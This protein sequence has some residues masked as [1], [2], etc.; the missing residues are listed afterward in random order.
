MRNKNFIISRKTII[1]DRLK[2]ML[3]NTLMKIFYTNSLFEGSHK[4]QNTEMPDI[5]RSTKNFMNL[6]QHLSISLAN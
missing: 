3:Y 6:G 5:Q 1:D 2:G 4:D